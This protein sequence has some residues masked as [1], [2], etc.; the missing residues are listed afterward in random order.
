MDRIMQRCGSETYWFIDDSLK[1]LRDLDQDFNKPDKRITLLLAAWGYSGP[2]DAA[3]AH[4]LG[5]PVYAQNDLVRQMMK[6]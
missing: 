3:Y 6:D 2:D 4:E 1:N 5:Y